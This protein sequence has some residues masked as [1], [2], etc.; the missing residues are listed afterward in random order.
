MSSM[1]HSCAKNDLLESA[2]Q[3]TIGLISNWGT[4]YKITSLNSLQLSIL[5]GMKYYSRLKEV[6]GAGQ[7]NAMYDVCLDSKWGGKCS[8]GHIWCNWENVNNSNISVSMLNILTDKSD[9]YVVTEKNVLV[10]RWY[11][12]ACH[13][14][15]ATHFP[16]VEGKS[17][18]DINTHMGR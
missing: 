16:M 11:M 18:K 7:L 12:A 4:I 10:S 8:K 2:T 9:S 6:K 17:Y 13:V 3:K 5:Q 14:M 1:E 15:S